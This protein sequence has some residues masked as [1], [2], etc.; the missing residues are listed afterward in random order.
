M[1]KLQPARAVPLQKLVPATKLD[2]ALKQAKVSPWMA[3][4]TPSS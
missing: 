3:D 1:M 2:S 4:V